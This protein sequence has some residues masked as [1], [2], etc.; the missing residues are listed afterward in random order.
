MKEISDGQWPPACEGLPPAR[1]VKAGGNGLKGG[2]FKA[3]NDLVTENT[4]DGFFGSTHLESQP[5]TDGSRMTAG[6]QGHLG[7]HSESE[8]SL[9]C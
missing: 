1:G 7:L 2:N 5:L 3:S 4:Q 9:D 8:A 6:V